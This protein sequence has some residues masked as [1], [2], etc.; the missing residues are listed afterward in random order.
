MAYQVNCSTQ[1]ITANSATLAI[2]ISSFP[3]TTTLTVQIWLNNNLYDSF[4]TY[5]NGTEIYGFLN[6]SPN[7]N[8]SGIVYVGYNDGVGWSGTNDT[9]N[10]TT[11]SSS[12]GGTSGGG[13]WTHEQVNTVALENGDYVREE[14]TSP[15]SNTLDYWIVTFESTGIWTIT[16]DNLNQYYAYLTDVLSY[17]DQTGIPDGVINSYTSSGSIN[18]TVNVSAGSTYYFWLRTPDGARGTEQIDITFYSGGPTPTTPTFTYNLNDTTLTI[19]IL[20]P[21]SYYFRYYLRTNWYGGGSNE[22]EIYDSEDQTGGFESDTSKTIS[23]LDYQTPYALNV[24]YRTNRYSGSSTW[25]YESNPPTFTT[26]SAPSVDSYVYIYTGQ[27][28]TG[29]QKAIPYIYTG[30]GSE[31]GWQQAEAYIYNGSEW[32]K[33]GE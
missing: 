29:W 23:N 17:D 11:L 21:G 2:S 31:N 20:N 10:F 32:K 30:Y 19:N 22:T 14:R 6:L 33:C 15:K 18:F 9:F 16:A 28:S 24:A 4:T 25:V 12:G 1:N 3:S 5:G 13:T 27:G 26:G 8:Y 7:T